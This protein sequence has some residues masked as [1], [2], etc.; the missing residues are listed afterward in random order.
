MTEPIDFEVSH[1]YTRHAVEEYLQGVEVQRTELGAAIADA[2]ART[3]RASELKHRIASLEHQVGARIVLAHAQA[4]VRPDVS[5]TS[6]G[7]ASG[8]YPVGESDRG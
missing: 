2:R 7:R 8:S 4:D 1:A 6:P 5:A 3:A